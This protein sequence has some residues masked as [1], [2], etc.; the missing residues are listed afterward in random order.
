MKRQA[1]EQIILN[2]NEFFKK[3][4][5]VNVSGKYDFDRPAL[6]IC[7]DKKNK[8]MKLQSI[9]YSDW[10][11]KIIVLEHKVVYSVEAGETKTIL[12]R[13]FWDFE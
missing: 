4:V 1:I 10:D 3:N 11:R 6:E 8:S 2:T 7:W 5:F 12:K 13:G 9:C